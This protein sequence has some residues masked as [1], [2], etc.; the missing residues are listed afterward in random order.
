MKTRLLTSLFLLSLAAL[1]FFNGMGIYV[2]ACAKAGIHRISRKADESQLQ[3]L[4]L[5]GTELSSIAWIGKADFIYNG[6]IYD[7]KTITSSNGKIIVSCYADREETEMKDILADHFEKHASHPSPY[8]T[9]K[10]SFKFF[11]VFPFAEKITFHNRKAQKADSQFESR[12]MTFCAPDREI[13]SPPPD[14]A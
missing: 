3:R 6:T 13:A 1:V 10:H 14:K 11:P 8:K 7:C 12:N 2:V 9:L 5:N 4:V